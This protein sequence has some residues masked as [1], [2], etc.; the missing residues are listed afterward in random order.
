[1]VVDPAVV[2]LLGAAEL[3]KVSIFVASCT[4]RMAQLFTGLRGGDESRSEDVDFYLAT[5]D[6]LW[7]LGGSNDDFVARSEV[8][9][10]FVELEPSEE[11]LTDLSDIYSFYSVLCLRYAILF[12]VSGE[13]EYAMKCAHASLT[14]LGQLDRN[15]V[16][17]SFFEG[18]S[19]YQRQLFD[20]D[21]A[22]SGVT[23]RLRGRDRQIGLERYSAILSRRFK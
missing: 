23:L 10:E 4:E 16:G 22:E 13:V 17:T 12:R 19:E 9:K 7:I 8:L 1:M 15:A 2:E 3:S 5:L 20:G 21:T 14:A 18:E 6:D 11:G